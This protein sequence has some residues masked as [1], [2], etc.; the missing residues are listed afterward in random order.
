MAQCPCR[1][2]NQF[3]PCSRLPPENPL[4]AT[5]DHL[6]S[7]LSQSEVQRYRLGWPTETQLSAPDLY[8]SP[9]CVTLRDG[10]FLTLPLSDWNSLNSRQTVKVALSWR[11]GPH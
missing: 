6:K 3:R 1:L 7:R 8:E 11:T 9:I 2:K 10:T 4:W 5:V